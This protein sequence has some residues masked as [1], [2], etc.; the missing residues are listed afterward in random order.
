[1]QRSNYDCLACFSR[2]LFRFILW[3]E[4]VTGTHV[5]TYYMPAG[6]R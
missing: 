4:Y 6:M 5:P 3:I 2:E 1:M